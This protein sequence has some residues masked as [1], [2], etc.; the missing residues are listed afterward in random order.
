MTGAHADPETLCS[1]LEYRTTE[2]VQKSTN[3]M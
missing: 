2:K 1:I 3:I